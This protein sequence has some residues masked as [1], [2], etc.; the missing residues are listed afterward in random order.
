MV[1]DLLELLGL[2]LV[3]AFLWFVWPPL[4]LLGSGLLI[5]VWANVRGVGAARAS[6]ET[7]AE[8]KT[9]EQKTTEPR[10]R[11]LRRAS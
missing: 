6:D 3:V 4:V 1:N 5:V 2:I 9:T 8:Q 11:R 10:M 7:N